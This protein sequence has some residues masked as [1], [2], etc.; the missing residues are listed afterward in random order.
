MQCVDYE[1]GKKSC[2]LY[3][4]AGER[5]A[6]INGEERRCTLLRLQPLTGRTHQL[7]V[8]C[9]HPDGL[10]APITGDNL[11]GTPADRL[12]L[13]AA[14]LHFGDLVIKSPLPFEFVE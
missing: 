10:N 14:E 13:H 3:E 4:V 6:I 5:T 2:T 7:R 1:K 11:Y 8:H 9:A 12:Y